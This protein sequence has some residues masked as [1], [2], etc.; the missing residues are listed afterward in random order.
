MIEV[1]T[2][3]LRSA[4]DIATFE[5][6]DE[7]WRQEFVYRQPGIV[8]QTT[9][10]SDDGTWIHLTVWDNANLASAAA[11]AATSDCAAIELDAAV[12]P[13]SI[14]VRRFSTL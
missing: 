11:S 5:A 1:K 12:E 7:R 9:A 4:V 6:L 3:R 2:F 14:D 13:G 8:R 10:R